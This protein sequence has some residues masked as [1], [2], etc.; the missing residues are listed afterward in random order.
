VKFSK[1][2]FTTMFRNYEDDAWYIVMVT[3]EVGTTL[4]ARLKKI[5]DGVDQLF[6]PS[7]FGSLEDLHNFEKRFIP[8]SVQVQDNEC[9][10][11]VPYAVLMIFV[12]T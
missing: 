7:F 3:I 8:L 6:E 12:S 2:N 1:D 4:R 10:K 11:L 5:T 9:G